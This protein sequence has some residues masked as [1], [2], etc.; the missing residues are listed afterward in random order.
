VGRFTPLA[1]IAAFHVQ[2]EPV[3]PSVALAASYEPFRV[4]EARRRQVW[5]PPPER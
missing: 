4:G 2:G 5:P 3:E 1:D